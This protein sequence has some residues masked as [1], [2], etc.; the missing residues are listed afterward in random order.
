MDDVQHFGYAA[1]L[2]LF[3]IGLAGLIVLYGRKTVRFP[4]VRS[5]PLTFAALSAVAMVHLFVFAFLAPF[6]FLPVGSSIR[7]MQLP[8]FLGLVALAS[9]IVIEP[10][11]IV[12]MVKE[13]PRW[14]GMAGLLGG[15]TPAFFG[16]ILFFLAIQLNG[17]QVA[18]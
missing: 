1:G 13:K 17:L 16:L 10:I 8:A 5:R 7:P 3:L 4:I 11:S 15:I 6:F 14:L 2:P 9:F 18:D 12:A